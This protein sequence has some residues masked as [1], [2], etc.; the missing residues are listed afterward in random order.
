MQYISISFLICIS[1]KLTKGCRRRWILNRSLLIS[2]LLG[3]QF[4]GDKLYEEFA[5]LQKI[6]ATLN[7]EQNRKDLKWIHFFKQCRS[8]ELSKLLKHNCPLFPSFVLF[9]SWKFTK[10][11]FWDFIRWLDRSSRFHHM[12]NSGRAPLALLV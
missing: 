1:E 8:P 6:R 11:S 10:S 7:E 12:Y 3:V 2:K 9:F 4:D 5:T